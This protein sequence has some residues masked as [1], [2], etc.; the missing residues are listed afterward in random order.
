M[1]M[2]PGQ[3]D[4]IPGISRLKPSGPLASDDC[5]SIKSSFSLLED[6]NTQISTG[7]ITSE[8][9]LHD[10]FHALPIFTHN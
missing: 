2:Q 5:Q 10:P 9:F 6:I 1:K 3:G 8:I 4:S 7:V